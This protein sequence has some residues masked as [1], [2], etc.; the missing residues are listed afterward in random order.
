M[1]IPLRG[2]ATT[3]GLEWD[4]EE[5]VA[6]NKNLNRTLEEAWG[7]LL[8]VLVESWP[9]WPIE[10]WSRLE[11]REPE[12]DEAQEVQATPGAEPDAKVE[13]WV[14]AYRVSFANEGAENADVAAMVT[15]VTRG[16]AAVLQVAPE[17]SWDAIEPGWKALW[18]IDDTQVY[19]LIADERTMEPS[20]W[21][22]GQYAGLPSY[23]AAT[24]EAWPLQGVRLPLKHAEADLGWAFVT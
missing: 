4:L 15:Y 23:F 9:D 22:V 11:R 1:L 18:A 12:G 3:L 2:G 17:V 20:L 24:L 19:R 6:L 13:R 5:L 21:M 7:G 16:L 8:T 14:L 10:V